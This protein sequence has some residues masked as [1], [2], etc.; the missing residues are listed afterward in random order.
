[1]TPRSADLAYSMSTVHQNKERNIENLKILS[2][3]FAKAVSYTHL[4][5]VCSCLKTAT[6]LLRS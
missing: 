6:D 5:S 4:F 3:Q 2:K 1:M